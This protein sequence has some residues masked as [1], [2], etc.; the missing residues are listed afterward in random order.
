MYGTDFAVIS[1]QKKYVV[2]SLILAGGPD[3]FSLDFDKALSTAPLFCKFR[4]LVGTFREDFSDYYADNK[5][6]ETSSPCQYKDS[7]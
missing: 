6:L 1:S 5:S 3:P 2:S 4:L 7:V